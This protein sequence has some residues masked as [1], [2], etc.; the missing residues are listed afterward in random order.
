MARSR[1]LGDVYKRQHLSNDM[2]PGYVETRIEQ[3]K[4]SKAMY[5]KKPSTG[6]N[7]KLTETLLPSLARLGRKA[8]KAM[9]NIAKR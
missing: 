9:A 7:G 2:R 6:P 4:H 1:G 8:R 5:A 3:Q